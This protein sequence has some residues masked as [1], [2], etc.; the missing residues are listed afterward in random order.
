MESEISLQGFLVALLVVVGVGA[1]LPEHL[2][3]GSAKMKG[4]WKW[5]SC[6]DRKGKKVACMKGA[7]PNDGAT[8]L[9]V[10]SSESKGKKAVIL[11]SVKNIKPNWDEF[12]IQKGQM[13]FTRLKMC[14]GDIFA[15]GKNLLVCLPETNL[16]ENY[17]R[18]K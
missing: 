11:K 18:T 8:A 1:C 7:G 10:M 14:M 3:A 15:L 13:C 9:V 6:S 12:V 16:C 4:K 17:V 2:S 5:T